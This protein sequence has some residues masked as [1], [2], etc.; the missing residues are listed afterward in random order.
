MIK[1]DNQ[2][3][4]DIEAVFTE[5]EVLEAVKECNC[6]KAPSPDGFKF[7]FFYLYWDL[8]KNDLLKA[9]SWFWKNC[10]TSKG[11]NALFVSLV[12]KKND[13]MDLNDY[14]P[15]SI[16][17][18]LPSVIGFEQSAYLKGR[19]ILDGSLIANEAIDYLKIIK[20]K[21][22]IFKLDF[23]KAF[24]SLSWNFLF[25][26]MYRM[27]FGLRW[28]NWIRA[29][30][31][32][33]SISVLVNAS[34]TNE[35]LTER[36]VRQGDPLS[37]SP[38]L[39]AVEGLNFIIK[40]TCDVGLFNGV[41]VDQHMSWVT[42]DEVIRP[43]GLGGLNLGSLKNKNLA[44]IGK[45]WWMFKTETDSLWVK[46][47]SSIYGPSGGLLGVSNLQSC[48]SKSTWSSIIAIGNQIEDFGVTFKG[49]F[50]RKIS[51]G[52]SISFWG[53]IWLDNVALKDKYK[54]LARLESKLEA[55][56]KERLPWNGSRVAVLWTWS[57]APFGRAI[58]EISEIEE[59]LA[60]ITMEPELN[61]SWVWGSSNG[62]NF[63]TKNLT[64]FI[65]AKTIGAGS[66]ARETLKNNLVPK[67]VEVFIWRARKGRIPVHVEL[68]KRWIDLHS[69]RCPLCDD[70]I[71]SVDDSLFSC[72][73]VFEI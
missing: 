40:R 68:D 63:T 64:N 28:R 34:P 25:D 52:T 16:R 54:R 6:L 59:M 30:L 20:K 13:P 71:E 3:A 12:P 65:N 61:D 32:S 72:K 45:W 9:L 56:V 39:I 7:K 19:F 36:G 60:S 2:Q 41:E 69:V 47:I 51:D 1:I 57:R 15:I 55:I 14:R 5:R 21:S 48:S 44:L 31:K 53:D 37:L 29:F 67:K 33:A 24:D 66:N 4:A 70:D 23:K 50:V 22:L 58:D 73:K 46:V 26:I 27:G 42:W 18:V 17:K 38:F 8:I 43:Y 10:D 62:G 35:F 11:C 49:S